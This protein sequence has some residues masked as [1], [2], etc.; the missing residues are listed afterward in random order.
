MELTA[1]PDLTSRGFVLNN[2]LNIAYRPQ[3]KWQGRDEANPCDNPP[4][5]I[6]KLVRL[7]EPVYGIRVGARTISKYQ[8]DYEC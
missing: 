2:P 4:G 3:D 1:G 7:L 6:T 8:E 5:G